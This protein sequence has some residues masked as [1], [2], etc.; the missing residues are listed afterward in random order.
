LADWNHRQN[1]RQPDEAGFWNR[2]HKNL[3]HV[4]VYQCTVR[5]P[6]SL[7]ESD[8]LLSCISTSMDSI[9]G[10]VPLG[11]FHSSGSNSWMKSQVPLSTAMTT[12][13]RFRPRMVTR[14]NV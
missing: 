9:N 7:A 4:F 5:P 11:F 3:R 14:R 8:A 6:P 2:V 12:G 1:L 10:T 13:R